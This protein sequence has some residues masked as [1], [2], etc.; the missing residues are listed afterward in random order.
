MW[1]MGSSTESPLTSFFHPRWG[2][3]TGSIS[4]SWELVRNADSRVPPRTCWI[5]LCF[6]R[7][8]RGFLCTSNWRNSNLPHRCLTRLGSS[9]ESP[10]ML[11]KIPRS[12]HHLTEAKNHHGWPRDWYFVPI[13]YLKM[14]KRI[15]MLGPRTH[16][17]DCQD[18]ALFRFIT[19]LC[20]DLSI[21]PS[22][23]LNACQSKLQTSRPFIPKH[24]S[25]HIINF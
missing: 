12:H 1:R 17:L 19:Y 15:E 14:F 21:N 22:R 16:H 5:G 4:L 11:K 23:F 7:I 6:H 8:S 25:T 9:S 10:A 3:C 20:T 13:F 24:L 2:L 18:F